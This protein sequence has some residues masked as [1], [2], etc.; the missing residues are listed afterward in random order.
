MIVV[1]KVDAF[2]FV[3]L[4]VSW[5]FVEL[6]SFFAFFF[7]YVRFFSWFDNI[8]AHLLLARFEFDRFSFVIEL[9]S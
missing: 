2:I 7:W 4:P 6:V 1:V 3:F 5:R 8:I 9:V